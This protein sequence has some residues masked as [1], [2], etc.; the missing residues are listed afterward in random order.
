[1]TPVP[2]LRIT[3]LRPEQA[4]SVQPLERPPARRY[5]RPPPPRVTMTG[6]INE[7]IEPESGLPILAVSV[8]DDGAQILCR[9]SQERFYGEDI[10]HLQAGVACEVSGGDGGDW[11]MTRLLPAADAAHI[12][13]SILS[14]KGQT[15]ISD[16][17]LVSSYTD[18]SESGLVSI[19]AASTQITHSDSDSDSRLVVE[20]DGIFLAG[21]TMGLYTATP[22]SP[23]GVDGAAP[24]E[25][26]LAV[27]A[28]SE[29]TE[30]AA[31]VAYHRL[32]L[33]LDAISSI[34]GSAKIQIRVAP[35]V[36]ATVSIPVSVNVPGVGRAR[37][38]GTLTTA[39]LFP[40]GVV[41]ELDLNDIFYDVTTRFLVSG[42]AGARVADTPTAT[43]DAPTGLKLE[44][45]GNT[46]PGLQLSWAAGAANLAYTGERQDLTE[47]G[48]NVIPRAI[49]LSL[50]RISGFLIPPAILKDVLDR[51]GPPTLLAIDAARVN[52]PPL[53]QRR[54]LPFSAA[55][56]AG[57]Y[58]NQ[59]AATSVVAGVIVSSPGDAL[60]GVVA[61][62]RTGAQVNA[63]IDYAAALSALGATA[64]SIDGAAASLGPGIIAREN[65]YLYSVRAVIQGTN[66][67][68]PR[69]ADA[70]IY[71][72]QLAEGYQLSPA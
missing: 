34:G 65:V 30:A 6:V 31:S 53:A 17:G 72:F 1:M 25:G 32:P 67:R 27:G 8:G 43:V 62:T 18:G 26:A 48:I 15:Q 35:T 47:T 40:D 66:L 41:G 5:T 57:V 55:A 23:A 54:A 61:V 63:T 46:S 44:I 51:S 29:Q 50:G 33:M 3:G 42:N 20:T 37:G 64:R 45:V 68:S 38:S 7:V 69:S 10:K 21:P 28:V 16:D 36:P 19:D 22:Q 49:I 70:V 60:A 9:P 24:P 14:G 12:T 56:T 52:S 11:V 59:P 71:A 13:A 4:Q 58:A 39:Q 2:G